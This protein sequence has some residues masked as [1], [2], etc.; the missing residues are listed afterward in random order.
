MAIAVF[1]L[2][3]DFAQAQAQSVTTLH[4]FAIPP[5]NA[6]VPQGSLA[7]GSDGNL[8]GTSNSGGRLNRGSVFSITPSGTVTILYSFGATA[9]DG[10]APTGGLVMGTG[11]NF[12]GTTR[13]GGANG[14][15]TIFVVTPAGNLTTL[16]NFGGSNSGLDLVNS[17]TALT[18]SSDGNLYGIASSESN[19]V[20]FQMSPAGAVTSISTFGSNSGDGRDPASPVVQ[21]SNGNFY[22]TTIAGGTKSEGTVFKVTQT[23]TYSTIYSFG[24]TA[25]DGEGP[26]GQVVVDSNG[27]IYGAT[28]FGGKKSL[29][30]IYKITPTGGFQTLHS[31]GAITGDGNTPSSLIQGSDGALYGT[32]SAGGAF[33]NGTA[34]KITTDGVFTTLSSFSAGDG[35]PNGVMLQATD[36]N[37]YGTS[38]NGSAVFKLTPAGVL[39]TLAD[40][41]Q[42]PDGGFPGSAVIKGSDGNFYGTTAG[43]AQIGLSGGGYGSVFKLSP[44]GILT[45]LHLFGSTPDDGQYPLAA[46]VEGLDG[47]FYGTTSGGGRHGHGT[48]YKITPSGVE[49]VLYS[50]GANTGDGAAPRCALVQ[51]PNGK[52][53]GTASAGGIRSKLGPVEG[54]GTVFSVTTSGVETTLYRFAGSQTDGRTPVAGLVLGTDGAFYGTAQYG[55]TN[56]QGTIYRIDTAGHYRTLYNFGTNDDGG[57][58]TAAPILGWDGDFYGTTPEATIFKVTPTGVF[59]Q[60]ASFES[61]LEDSDTT[62]IQGGLLQGGDGNFYGTTTFGGVGPFSGNGTIF[63]MTP[64]GVLTT[65]YEFGTNPDDGTYPVAGLAEGDDGTFYGTTSTGGV[66]AGGT[67]FK[68]NPGYASAA[69]VATDDV[70]ALGTKSSLI[71]YV[72]DND[73]SPAGYPLAITSVTQPSLGT[74]KINPDHRSVTYTPK[75]TYAAFTGSDPFTYTITD[76]QGA[77]ATAQV[78]VRNP[79]VLERGTFAGSE[80]TGPQAI[81]LSL[82]ASGSFTATFRANGVSTSFSGQFDVNGDYSRNIAGLPL[83]LHIDITRQSGDSGGTY[84]LSVSYPGAQPAFTAYHATTASMIPETGPYTLLLPAAD[85]QSTSAPAGTGMAVLTVTKKG[86]VTLAGRLADGTAFSSGGALTDNS[87]GSAHM[88]AMYSLLRVPPAPGFHVSGSLAGNLTFED[89]ANVSDCDGTWAWKV[90][91]PPAGSGTYSIDTN[92]SV[93]GSRYQAPKGKGSAILQLQAASPNATATLSEPDFSAALIKQLSISGLPTSSVKVLN[94]AADALTLAIH[95]SNGTLTGTFIHPITGLRTPIYS[96]IFQKQNMAGGYFVSKGDSGALS[97]IP[98]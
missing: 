16:Y 81:T 2:V 93:I 72:L 29:G 26:G 8:Y 83:S 52:F 40:F 6:N 7:Q 62:F 13:D 64:G 1:I 36:G 89:I 98:N 3:T 58:P 30:S 25:G 4:S 17:L 87:S 46:L 43:S 18:A 22:G 48:A 95:P 76:S 91:A 19:T 77:S 85:P 66:G 53:Y 79:Y 11:G 51:A 20:L 44:S 74:V 42:Q 45:T 12:Y 69:P 56:Q 23:G 5:I 54:R 38:N 37:F 73:Y 34:F 84:A 50:F 61:N 15:G 86:L 39:T 35:L 28:S 41:N 33:G 97:I 67:I 31:F 88:Y 78:T 75:G 63:K 57:Y 96:A 24:T 14:F 65:V 10:D 55:G 68:W 60:L 21:D 94:K 27:N 32:T 9:A 82:T 59:N 90:P 49:T 80:I 71:I 92:L 47:N 70:A